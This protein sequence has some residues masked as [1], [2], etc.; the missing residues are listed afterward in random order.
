MT[1]NADLAGQLE[2]AFGLAGLEY[3]YGLSQ[4]ALFHE[5]IANDRGRVVVGGPDDAQ[6][7]FA[8]SLGTD[9]PLVYYSDPECTGRPVPDTFCVDRPATTDRV[10]WKNGFAKFDADAFDALLPQSSPTST[11]ADATSM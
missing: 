6:K 3:R 8:T 10:W 5:A 11:N 1:T 4:E 9:G 2:S 7:A